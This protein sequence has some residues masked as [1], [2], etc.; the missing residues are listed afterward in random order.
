MDDVSQGRM[1]RF[2]NSRYILL[3]DG[4]WFRFGPQRYTV[5]LRALKRVGDH[6]ARFLPPIMLQ[7][8]ESAAC[9][10]IV[11][12]DIPQRLKTRIIAMVSDGWR[13]VERAADTNHWILQRCHFH[14]IAQLQVNRGKRK[15]MRDRAIR[16]EI[17]QTAR[18]V[19]TTGT[20]INRYKNRLRRLIGRSDCPRRLQLIIREFL[21]RL[22]DFRAYLNHPQFTLPTT[23]NAMESK[24]KQIRQLCRPLRTP[25][26][27]LKWVSYFLKLNPKITCNGGKTPQN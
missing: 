18:I 25:D 2:P 11:I 8:R 27:L 3:I 21:R 12:D 9:W 1:P 16:E 7:G 22:P 19:L 4:L 6:T 10:R 23:T 20:N 15:K 14:F 26:S 24:N 17:Y 5:Y 13:G